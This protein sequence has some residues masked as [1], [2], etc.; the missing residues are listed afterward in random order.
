MMKPISIFLI[1]CLAACTNN[2]TERGDKSAADSIAA[3]DS[4]ASEAEDCVFDLKAQNDSF[5]MGVEP[6]KNYVWVDSLKTAIVGMANGDTIEITRGGCVHYSYYISLNSGSDTTSF[7]N[8]QHW[9]NKIRSLAKHLPGFE[10]DMIDALISAK[11]YSVEQNEDL[12]VYSFEQEK[13]CY[14]ELSIQPLD[15]K[16]ILVELGYYLC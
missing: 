13:Y 15:G 11:R 9:I 10:N 4:A 2:N 1:V 12:Y 6:F 14:M 3:S 7:S 16:R 5:L 8:T